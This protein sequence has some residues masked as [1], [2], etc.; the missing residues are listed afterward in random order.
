[1]QRL[2]RSRV[3]A[4][5]VVHGS[6]WA[7]RSAVQFGRCE[8]VRQQPLDL[9]ALQPFNRPSTSLVLSQRLQAERCHCLLSAVCK[10]PS[11]LFALHFQ[12]TVTGQH[13]GR[14]TKTPNQLRN[15]LRLPSLRQ[16]HPHPRRYTTPP[17]QVRASNNPPRLGQRLPNLVLRRVHCKK[18]VNS[19]T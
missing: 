4:V 5:R 6:R 2:S 11:L 13:R 14:R 12:H 8:R 3:K 9:F 1:V 19:H 18:K 16:G 7:K 17:R 10:T 15:L